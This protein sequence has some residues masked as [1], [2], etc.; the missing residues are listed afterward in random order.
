MFKK[1]TED[2]FKKLDV[3]VEALKNCATNLNSLHE[4]I[5]N[6]LQTINEVK[7]EICTMKQ[8]M[9]DSQGVQDT[10]LTAIK[11]DIATLS[12]QQSRAMNIL[13][14]DLTRS[15]GIQYNAISDLS[16]AV[17]ALSVKLD[18]IEK[19]LAKSHS[20]IIALAILNILAVIVAA[21]I[22]ISI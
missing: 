11:S 22:R 20:A 14:E 5:K 6:T 21:I 2:E 3:N 18:T 8:T 10:Q 13:S 15:Q 9:I 16:A 17:S 12:A 1:N 19:R 7:Q 4:N